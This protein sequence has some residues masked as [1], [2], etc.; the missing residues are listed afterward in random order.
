MDGVSLE[1]CIFMD[2]LCRMRLNAQAQNDIFKW[3]VYIDKDINKE[4]CL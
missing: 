1:K 2:T 4:G 3:K